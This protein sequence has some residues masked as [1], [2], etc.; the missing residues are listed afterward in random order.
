MHIAGSADGETIAA[1]RRGLSSVPSS[2][3]ICPAAVPSPIRP[4]IVAEQQTRVA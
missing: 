1:L 2:S 3:S 4:L